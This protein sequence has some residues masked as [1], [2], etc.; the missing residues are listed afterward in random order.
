MHESWNIFGISNEEGKIWWGKEII[1]KT[2]SSIERKST[3][4]GVDIRICFDR[5]N[6]LVKMG[7]YKSSFTARFRSIRVSFSRK[8]HSH[9]H[10][11]RHIGQTVLIKTIL[12]ASST[13]I[14]FNQP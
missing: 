14:R 3:M 7:R 8:I 13:C 9:F 2:R 4:F 12:S 5:S 1:N 6:K 10:M 11:P